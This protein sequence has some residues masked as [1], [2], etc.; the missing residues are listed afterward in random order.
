[1]A[2]HREISD[3][4]EIP[5]WAQTLQRALGEIQRRISRAERDMPGGRTY[6][7][8]GDGLSPVTASETEQRRLQRSPTRQ[9]YDPR[10]E[11]GIDRLNT[12]G[13]RRDAL[14]RQQANELREVKALL[15][16]VMRQ[17]TEQDRNAL[18]AAYHRADSVYAMLGYA[19]PQPMP[20]EGSVAYR[21]RLADGLKRHSPSLRK[22]YMDS[23]RDDAFTVVES[24]I[25]Q[26]AEAAA[27]SGGSNGQLR[28]HAHR[29]DTGHNV[30]EYYGDPMAWMAPFMSGGARLRIRQ[31]SEIN[32]K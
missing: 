30:T 13:Q 18:A 7:L 27:R 32:R 23:L 12:Q 31:P 17:P 14:Y 28:P 21:H 9:S 8:P 19:T 22:T 3:R 1:M 24:R 4:E 25:Y 16:K 2:N 10:L 15:G 11:D 6:R 20:G 29:A 26:D 5:G